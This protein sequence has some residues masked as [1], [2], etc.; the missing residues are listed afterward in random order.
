MR[1]LKYRLFAGKMRMMNGVATAPASAQAALLE[2]L[3]KQLPSAPLE[4]LLL[5][6]FPADMRAALQARGHR[7][8]SLRWRD[9][10][11]QVLPPVGARGELLQVS[12]KGPA[13]AGRHFDA[14]LALDLAADIHP[15]ALFDELDGVLAPPGVVVLAATGLAFS[16][17]DYLAEISARCG[18]TMDARPGDAAA[19]SLLAH[20]FRRAAVA[21]R[22]RVAHVLP[23]DFP[24]VGA[25]FQAVFG[26]PLSRA[27]W[28]W[29]YG[30][31][32]GNAVMARKDG[33]VVAHYGGMYRNIL[34][35]GR[36]ERVAQI[37]DVMVQSQERGVLT[38][39]GPFFLMGTSWPEV[40][41]PLGFGFP[42]RRAMLVAKKMGLYTQVG[43]MA[44]VRWQP[45]SAHF[46]VGSRV[47]VL[48][49]NSA[50][51]Q[52]LVQP[53][54]DAMAHD[55][56]SSAVG[57]KNWEF[58][59]QRYFS[60]PHNHYEV[61]VVTARLTG[62]PLGIIVMRRLEASCELLDV[63]APLSNLPLLID[64]ARRMTGRWALP[65]LYCWITKNHLPLFLDC[66]GKEEALD[67]SIPASSWT[68]N[69]QSE[70][71]MDKWWLMSGDTDFR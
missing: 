30:T 64:Q 46:R 36:G 23:E 61:L 38:R 8:A 48:D 65:Y 43:Q 37:C 49:R 51:D 44:E 1:A 56:R 9:P 2:E 32:R 39:Q 50:A 33:K 19:G 11:N 58:L 62:K 6:E 28:D 17:L 10:Q 4:L 55:L 54:W 71:F 35:G 68:K 14:V 59:Q 25:L 12:L 69:P 66:G 41:G 21:P 24:E 27:L 47:R 60:H 40:Y 3:E 29:K 5:G 34:V 45:V 20:V 7:L 18:F 22:W 53:L 52:A 67:L 70:L 42:T 15:L 26:H 31:G 57:V 13:T 16:W 63:I